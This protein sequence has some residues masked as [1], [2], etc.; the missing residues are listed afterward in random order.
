MQSI[1]EILASASPEVIQKIKSIIDTKDDAKLK[2]Y[3]DS[4]L[5]KTPEK[6][7]SNVKQ[8]AIAFKLKNKSQV[9]SYFNIADYDWMRFKGKKAK[10]IPYNGMI[11]KVEP[12]DIF[13][14]AKV[15]DLY[16]NYKCIMPS[17]K[18]QLI[19]LEPSIVGLIRAK[20]RPFSGDIS[21]VMKAAKERTPEKIQIKSAT[22]EKYSDYQ[23][24][25]NTNVDLY[26]KLL[27]ASDFA[28]KNS[29]SLIKLDS[30]NDLSKVIKDFQNKLKELAHNI[31]D[32]VEESSEDGSL[33]ESDRSKIMTMVD[34]I[35]G[36]IAS[37]KKLKRF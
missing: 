24:I 12:E 26:N 4:L 15:V 18:R 23:K 9:L 13:G 28:G 35:V 11:L 8:K 5:D 31:A 6:V 7:E 2:E 30:G 16:G 3:L 25:V 14:I 20:C 36:N 19:S 22:Y 37:G 29:G 32:D 10:R 33:K 1:K 21:C 17:Y 27:E 34:Y